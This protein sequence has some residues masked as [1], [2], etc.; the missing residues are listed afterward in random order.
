MSFL[1]DASVWLASA[2][3]DDTFHQPAQ[4]LLRT[5][6]SDLAALDLTVYEVGNVAARRWKDSE[7]A[8]RLCSLVLTA[9]GDRLLR[10]NPQLAEEAVRLAGQERITVYD[11]AHVAAARGHGHVLVSGDLTDLVGPGLALAPDV[12]ATE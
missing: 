3:R 10:I 11:A 5:Q 6:Q 7:R 12:A 2:D 1:L 9:C 4:R 8:Q